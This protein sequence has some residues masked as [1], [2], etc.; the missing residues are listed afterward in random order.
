M[1]GYFES[2][3]ERIVGVG[4]GDLEY[5]WWT[6]VDR[7][8]GPISSSGS[9]E[10][11]YCA[12]QVGEPPPFSVSYFQSYTATWFL[13]G[14]LRTYRNG[15]EESVMD[16]LLAE[17][18][19]V[20]T[21]SRSANGL[22]LNDGIASECIPPL[23]PCI[24]LVYCGHADSRV[25]SVDPS[26]HGDFMR[27]LDIAS[28]FTDISGGDCTDSEVLTYTDHDTGFLTISDAWLAEQEELYG[29]S[30]YEP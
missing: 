11:E 30:K 14:F 18:S 9:T 8:N 26:E 10:D 13:R 17:H 15:E 25:V 29:D 5:E 28:E 20:L 1:P 3:F 6:L 19:E 2:P 7:I 23:H 16:T 21:Y 22:C 12:A 24:A 27:L 4:W